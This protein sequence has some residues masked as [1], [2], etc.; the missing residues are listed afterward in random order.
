[1]FYTDDVFWK[2]HEGQDFDNL[3]MADDIDIDMRMYHESAGIT[4]TKYFNMIA[5]FIILI[6]SADRPG[7]ELQSIRREEDLR[8][9]RIS[10]ET[11]PEHKRVGAFEK[12]TKVISFKFL[13]VFC[14]FVLF[15]YRVSDDVY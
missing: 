12:H 11:D 7:Y 9:G 13:I 5:I 10:N 1:V 15:N 2:E 4:I 6:G 3:D 14:S 8:E